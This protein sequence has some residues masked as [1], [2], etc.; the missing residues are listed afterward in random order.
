MTDTNRSAQLV[1]VGTAMRRMLHSMENA[2]LHAARTQHLHPTDFA[3]LGL[4]AR[5]TV[6]LSPKDIINQLDLSSGSVTALLDRLER[7]GYITRI[8]NPDDRRGLLVVLDV[9]AA[10]EPMKSYQKIEQSY[11]DA[12]AGFSTEELAMIAK[13]LEGMGRLAEEMSGDTPAPARD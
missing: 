8:A 9:V 10:G 5:S 4:L 1:R 13:F 7:A 12:T 3:C 6:P 2:R 11:R